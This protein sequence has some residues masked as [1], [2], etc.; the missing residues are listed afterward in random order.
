MSRFHSYINSSVKLIET[1]RGDQPFAIFIKANLAKERKFGSRDR[2]QITS[3]CYN[4]FRMGFAMAQT[5]VKEKI[6][7]AAFLCTN[8]SSEF[9]AHIRPELNNA[10]T[11]S[12]NEK[13]G[14][15]KNQ[16][17]LACVFPFGQYISDN[18]DAE[19]YATAMFTQPSF[20]LRLRPNHR[21]TMLKKLKAT[22]LSYQV[23]N[24]YCVEL[25]Q[26]TDAEDFFEVDREAV[27]Q[28]FNSQQVFNYLQQHQD[29]LLGKGKK[30][31][32]LSAWD[33]CAAS[34]GKS[35]LLTDILNNKINLTVS[36]I[37]LGIL[38]NLHQR[39]KKAQIKQYQYFV[40]DISTTDFVAPAV[41]YDVIICDAPCT[42]SG[43]WGRTPEQLCFFKTPAIEE[44]SSRQKKIVANALHHLKPGGIFV[45]ITCSVFKAENE[46]VASFIESNFSLK[47]LQQ[48]ILSGFD[49]KADTMFVATF[50][51]SI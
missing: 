14:L 34:G 7:T 4:Y 16:F 45:Y 21:L 9:L 33:C 39:F 40:A 11:L 42:G 41:S 47:I 8:E 23:L 46:E 17:S 27:V 50:Q 24:G 12:F 26:A 5:P 31:N 3:L 37:R 19:S 10:V 28:D 25:P 29:I 51:K 43:T 36:D 15:L 18:L 35:I 30:A 1:Y 2:K 44:Y 22:K 49:K 20:F 6:I 32:T 13:I 38:I 48:Q